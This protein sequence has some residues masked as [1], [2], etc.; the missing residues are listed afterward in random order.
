MDR[1]RLPP[2]GK[3]KN[4]SE[5]RHIV[6]VARQPAARRIVDIQ[7]LVTDHAAPNY[8][9]PFHEIVVQRSERLPGKPAA[10]VKAADI[11]A[12]NRERRALARRWRACCLG[13]WGRGLAALLARLAPMPVRRRGARIVELVGLAVATDAAHGRPAL[14]ERQE[15]AVGGANVAAIDRAPFVWIVWLLIGASRRQRRQQ[16]ES[17]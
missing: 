1:R 3:A 9:F 12:H 4:R 15:A 8:I 17:C 5:H 6:F 13:L 7:S 11:A 10:D 16:R 14:L 2:C